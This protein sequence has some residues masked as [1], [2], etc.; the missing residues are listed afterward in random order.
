M[1]TALI[2]KIL[3]PDIAKLVTMLWETV[4]N[5]FQP[6][7]MYEVTSYDAR[8]EL[9]DPK[10]EYAVFYK[11]QKVKF[12]QDNII[13]YHDQAWGEGDIFADYKCSPGV[14]VDR[15]KEGKWYRVLISLRETK[16]RGDT[17]EF[18]IE[19][20]IRNGFTHRDRVHYFQSKVNHKMD[21]LG[22]TLIFPPQC[23]PKRVVLVEHNKARTT[24]LGASNANALPDGRFEVAWSTTKPKLHELYSLKWE[25]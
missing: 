24:E 5:L 13:A 22:M 17:E 8:L 4:S 3:N 25:W 18:Y 2:L 16:N 9:R 20:H 21:Y 7:G 23:H 10:G 19:R 15:Y 12:L 11:K 1:N 14:P 6:K